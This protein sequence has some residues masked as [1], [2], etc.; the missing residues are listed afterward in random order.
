MKSFQILR[1]NPLLTTNLKI[2]IDSKLNIYLSAIKSNSTLNNENYKHFPITRESY[3][4]KM[5]PIFYDGLSK[6]HAFFVKNDDDDDVIY[7]DYSHQFDNL[8]NSG[9]DYISDKWYEEEFEYF[10]PLYIKKN[11]LP[12]G[13][14]ILR[15][16][17][18]TVY[19]DNNGIYDI[20]VLNNE[21]FRKEIIDKWKCVSYYDITDK[22][23]IGYWLDKNINNNDRFPNLSFDLDMK[24]IS[25]PRWF[26]MDYD[27]GVYTQKTKYMSNDLVFEQPHFKFEKMITEGYKTNSLIYPHI[28]NFNFLFN[29]TPATPSKLR[30]YSINRYLG[31][32]VDKFEFI[33][34]LTSY[35]TPKLKNNTILINNVVA[36]Q[37]SYTELER[38]D[39][40]FDDVDINS[41]NPFVDSWNDDKNYYVYI[42]D[43]LYQVKKFEDNNKI[44]YKILSDDIMDN[45][46]NPLT[47]YNNT[48]DILNDG[49]DNY[50]YIEPKEINFN[51]DEYVN[52]DGVK[53]SMYADIYL[54]KIHD[55]YHVLK[56]GYEIFNKNSIKDKFYIQSDYAILSNN[57]NLEYWIGGKTSKYY[58][59]LD[60]DNNIDKPLIYPI[61][62]ITFSEI[63]DFDFDRID[64]KFTDFDYEQSTYTETKE[65]KIYSV[66]HKS[67]SYPKRY[68][69]GKEGTV[70]QDKPVIVSSEYIASDELYENKN[71]KLSDIWKK[72]QSICK[73]GFQLSLSHSDY[74][75]KLNNNNKV[76]S[77]F[78]RT[79]DVFSNKP[80]I[81]KKNLDY[82]Y[83]VGN[84]LKNE[85]NPIFYLNQTTNI[86]TEFIN[87][88]NEYGFQLNGGNGFNIGIYFEKDVPSNF[89]FDYFDFFFNNKMYKKIN[90][91]LKV[92]LYKKYSEFYVNDFGQCVTL[93]KGIK[94]L[95]NEVIDIKRNNKNGLIESITSD[96]KGIYEDYK[97]SIILNDVYYKYGS[98][99]P[100][101]VNGIINYEDLINVTDDGIHVILNDIYKNIL[102]IINVKIEL[103]GSN[104]ETFNYVSFFNEKDGLYDN[105]NISGVTA[106]ST[107]DNNKLTALNF[108]NAINDPNNKYGFDNYIKYYHIK[109]EDDMTIVDSLFINDDINYKNPSI[110]LSIENPELIK[111]K[112]TYD[113][114]LNNNPNLN[115]L[116]NRSKDK[117][118]ILNEEVSVEL[119]P[120]SITINKN[121]YRYSGA[122][123]PIFKKINIFKKPI[124]CYTNYNSGYTIDNNYIIKKT[125]NAKS[126][127]TGD[128]YEK[129]IEWIDTENICD[130]LNRNTYTYTYL[131]QMLNYAGYLK[132]EYLVCNNFDF[133]LPI[134]SQISGIT[135]TINRRSHVLDII[136]PNN[137]YVKDN[138]VGFISNVDN[139]LD[140]SGM[141]VNYAK[142][143]NWSTIYTDIIYGGNNI[144]WDWSG[145]TLQWT[146]TLVNSNKFG[147]MVN[148]KM[149]NSTNVIDDNKS[150]IMSDIKCITVRIDYIYN[151]KWETFENSIYFNGNQKFDETLNNFGQVDEIIYSKV[152][153]DKLNIIK[154]D[155]A[156]YPK[157]DQF[158]YSY[159]NRFIFKSDWDKN[160]YY[161]TLN[162]FTDD[163][164]KYT[165]PNTNVV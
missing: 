64:T 36:L 116:F 91:E 78:N 121:I 117:F 144:L 9:S 29:D 21:N 12:N 110:V 76:G 59:K 90:N 8:Y 133:N 153:I 87:K 57:D 26:G 10:A 164:S 47:V 140:S 63:K 120:S 74:P 34:N 86:Q 125:I 115:K 51:I 58:K 75:Y 13:F 38:C 18:P 44:Y 42:K 35:I 162:S 31:F 156:K 55:K 113:V 30:K 60:I 89:N 129:Y 100:Y 5:I 14:L 97:F 160:Y 83:R 27:T 25:L 108:I 54:I 53:K 82:F 139:Y 138:Y 107:F 145:S 122:Y 71:G 103:N 109:K 93:F 45:Y 7:N 46:W 66:N 150:Y 17:E 126:K 106:S 4:E 161:N 114:K 40:N 19:D 16:D 157:L 118:K 20:G 67:N 96:N 94:L 95:I 142:N 111:L 77:L 127:E 81:Y 41:I 88:S 24:R 68:K 104:N 33:T 155:I 136:P 15:V 130:V 2:D 112:K 61:Y 80:D 98:N 49:E 65:E 101:K 6:E 134:D 131:P 99:R 149:N 124:F 48:V 137:K 69:M 159:N 62:K 56:N 105:I 50:S 123:E 85:N 11:K 1:T 22:S 165:N 163:E 102:I 3:L 72:N 135:L 79:V 39:T 70:V 146:P 132:S 73:W 147:V 52:C 43:D 23:D 143:N 154:T 152:N 151:K 119:K 32:Y 84:L 37:G 141:T 158:G 28:L 148:C 128:I 92:D